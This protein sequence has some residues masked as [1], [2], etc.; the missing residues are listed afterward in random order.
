MRLIFIISILLMSF[1][2]LAQ[3]DEGIPTPLPREH[4]QAEIDKVMA[5]IEETYGI[6][7]A[8]PSEWI[9][10]NANEVIWFTDGLHEIYQAL[11]IASYYLYLYGDA[12]EG[13]TPIEFF[14]Q[15]F[16]HAH[17]IIDRAT[18][19][20]GG[21][22]GNTLPMYENSEVIGYTIQLTYQGMSGSFVLIHELG[23][24]LDNLLLETPQKQF[25]EALGGEWS[26]ESWIP[27]E[28]YLGNELFFPRA[29]GGPN[30]D[31][32]DTFANMLLGY[33]TEDNI[34][35]RYNFMLKNLPLWLTDLRE[36]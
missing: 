19:I 35:V 33:L 21:F 13:T 8:Y 14:R 24:V 27:G 36:E 2:A 11:N 9:A 30:E 1:P 16:D 20:E 22:W 23:H 5:L 31:F 4:R 25:V 18:T 17:I 12:P 28:G 15:H 7:F 34:P 29:L 32:A 3:E 26:T 10:S 6:G